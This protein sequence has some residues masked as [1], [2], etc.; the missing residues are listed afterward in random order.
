MLDF[1]ISHDAEVF[2]DNID[3]K[4]SKTKYDN[5]ESLSEV[6]YFILE[7]LQTLNCV[8]LTLKF[9]NIK[10]FKEKSYF[11]Q[12]EIIIIEYLCDYEKKHLKAAKIIKIVN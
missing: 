1:N 5:E 10:V 2:I 7:H 11:D 9:M 3:I 12:L 4:K 6:C 8:L